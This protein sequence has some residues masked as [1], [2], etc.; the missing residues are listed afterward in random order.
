MAPKPRENPSLKK[1]KKKERDLMFV[2][3]EKKPQ[4]TKGEPIVLKIRKRVKIEKL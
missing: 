4:N 3:K 1:K 2:K